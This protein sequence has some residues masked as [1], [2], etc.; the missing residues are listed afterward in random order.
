MTEET[1]RPKTIYE[2]FVEV[3]GS[4][5]SLARNKKGH[6]GGKNDYYYADIEAVIDATQELLKHNGLALAQYVEGDSLRAT[7]IHVSGEKIEFG[8]YNLGQ[9]TDHQKRG[10]AITYARRYQL[11][12]IFGIAQ[13][14]TDAANQ[15]NRVVTTEQA[16]EIDVLVKESK[17]DKAKFLAHFGVN[18]VR[19]I[20]HAKF[21][22]AKTLLETKKAKN[23][24]T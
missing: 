13:E 9:L 20:P 1:P 14:D 4:V 12:S 8:A 5:D 17:A 23:A 16:S 22:E 21:K 2:A 18:D 6:V 19:L 24:N 3:C 11:C 10:G 15:V 7:L